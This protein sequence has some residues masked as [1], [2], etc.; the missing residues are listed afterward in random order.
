MVCTNQLHYSSPSHVGRDETNIM[1]HQLR[2]NHVF[3]SLSP[4][5]LTTSWNIWA[6]MTVLHRGSF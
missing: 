5:R 2:F 3:S 1:T 4:S 6:S